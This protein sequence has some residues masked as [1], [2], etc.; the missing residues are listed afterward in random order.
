MLIRA[1]YDEGIV[2]EGGDKEGFSSLV[3]YPMLLFLE[4][5]VMTF[6]LF[7]L[8]LVVFCK[9]SLFILEAINI[10]CLPSEILLFGQCRVLDL[11][12]LHIFLLLSFAPPETGI[13]L[14]SMS[15]D[16]GLMPATE[17]RVYPIFFDEK[18]HLNSLWMS[19]LDRVTITKLALVVPSCPN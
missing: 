6:H 15:P 3:L 7:I 13:D 12:L 1:L 2:F 11:L 4:L 14:S 19:N 5:F 9:L 8:L 17:D 10:F 16:E 18:V